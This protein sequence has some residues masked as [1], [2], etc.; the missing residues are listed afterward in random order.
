MVTILDKEFPTYNFDE[1]K[2]NCYGFIYVTVNNK[3]NKMYVGMHYRWEKSYL[4][5]GVILK[6]AIKREGRSSFTRYIIDTADSY[7]ALVDLEVYYITQAFGVNCTKHPLFYNITDKPY[8]QGS[9]SWGYLTQEQREA[10]VTKFTKTLQKTLSSLSTEE[11]AQRKQM[12]RDKANKAYKNDP[13]LRKRVSEGTRK[14]MTPE[15]RKHLSEV[16][17]GVKQSISEEE[18]SRRAERM[19]AVGKMRTNPW[20][21]GI[22]T[23]ELLGA[24]M[25][26]GKRKYYTVYLN[27]RLLLEHVSNVG[28][29]QEIA[30][31][32]SKVLDNKPI[33]KNNV[34]NLIATGKPYEAKV[35]HK[36]FMNGLRI[37]RERGEEGTYDKL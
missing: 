3:N 17:T 9:T 10:R 37:V 34:S 7:D 23:K 24:K 8:K 27:D 28:G 32:I 33:G 26:E 5:S 16:K 12:Y 6:N 15:V 25:S 22:S 35:P 11:L 30:N 18:R 29:Y 19:R 20:N 13:E 36:Q 14:G 4:G 1:I 21:K 31:K 2:D